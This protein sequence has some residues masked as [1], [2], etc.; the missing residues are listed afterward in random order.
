M[1][2]S[3]V[4]MMNRIAEMENCILK[5]LVLDEL[6][7]WVPIADRKAVEEDTLA[8][9]SSGQVLF[10]GRWVNFPELKKSRSRRVEKPP[11]FS[12]RIFFRKTTAAPVSTPQSAPPTPDTSLISIAAEPEATT[13]GTRKETPP[14]KEPAAP[15]TSIII[16]T[17]EPEKTAA[18]SQATAPPS[19]QETVAPETSIISISQQPEIKTAGE[20]APAPPRKQE[21][22]A[23]ETSIIS[24]P[25]GPEKKKTAAVP[26]SSME[27][28]IILHE[29]PPSHDHQAGFHDEFAPE[30]KIILFKPPEQQAHGA[31]DTHLIPKP[32]DTQL[33]H[34]QKP[35]PAQEDTPEPKNRMVLIIGAVA[36]A[37]VV[38]AILFVVVQMVR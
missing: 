22:A 17:P 34:L 15:D 25:P 20:Q 16:M 1:K 27:T 21:A 33:L 19:Q 35:T 37:A 30:T 7:N 24:L 38:A 13:A 28:S 18:G 6:G 2:Q 9:L 36:A 3:F 8:H 5:G 23:P 31:S 11:L 4:K 26:F 14:V 32:G 10:E 12:G 29:P